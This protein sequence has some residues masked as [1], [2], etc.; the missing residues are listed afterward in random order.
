MLNFQKRTWAILLFLLVSISSSWAQTGLLI[1]ELCDPR[2]NYVDDRF[3][4]IY[5][6][7]ATPISLNGWSLVAVGN[8]SDIFT[9]QL[10]GNIQP[11]QALV[12]GDATTVEPFDVD[13]PDEAWSVSN[14]TW[15]GKVG[16]GAKLINPDDTIVDAMIAPGTTF[17][18][19][20]M[21]RNEDVLLANPEYDP[22]E[23]TITPVDLATEASPGTHVTVG[24]PVAN[25]RIGAV[26]I[27][28]S[29]PTADDPVNVTAFVV[30]TLTTIQSV[31]LFWGES[32]DEL[33]HEIIMS[34]VS[35]STYTT[36]QPIPAQTGGTEVFFMIRAINAIPDTTSSIVHSYVIPSIIDIPELQGM[37]Y[38]SPYAG[39]TVLTS[40]VIM[41]N[42]P[43]HF[44]IQDGSGAWHGVWVRTDDEYSLGDSVQVHGTVTED[45][46]QGFLATTL[47]IDTSVDVVQAGV[48]MHAPSD[49]N[50]DQAME[51]AYEGVLV[52]IDN[53]VCTDPAVGGD[54][55]WEADDGTGDILIDPLGVT[56]EPILG[57]TYQIT[58]IMVDVDDDYMLVPRDESDIVWIADD[59][60]PQMAS[61]Y[62]VDVTQLVVTFTEAVDEQSAETTQNYHVDDVAV[63]TC[64]LTGE[65]NNRVVL[66][67]DTLAS[68]EHELVVIAVE[69][70]YGN[71]IQS[72]TL[73]F[74]VSTSNEPEGYYLAAEGLVGEDLQ[75]AL[76]DIIDDHDAHSYTY[77]WTAFY[78]TD[79]KPNG[80]VWDIYSDIPGGDPPYEYT[81]GEDQGGI[82]GA[83][84]NGYT[85]EHSWPRSWFGG[86]V[87]PMNS[88][89]Y[90]IYP[91]DAHVNGN[92]GNYPYGEVDNATWTSMN[93]SKV[94]PCTV[95]GYTGTVFE[96]IDAYKGDLARTYFYMVTRYYGE[97]AAW[98]GSPMTD[99]ANLLPWAEEML[100]EWHENDP[101]SQKEVA[102]NNAAYLIQDN[103]NPF[104]DHPDFVMQMF[105]PL[106]VSDPAVLPDEWS[107]GTI[108]PNPFN[109]TANIT[110]QLTQPSYLEV[111]VY[112]TL[113]QQVATLADDRFVAGQLT[114]TF[115]GSAMSTGL[116]FIHV[117][118]PGHLNETR[119][120]L[121]L[122]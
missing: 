112:N 115:D 90:A 57:T 109:P 93:G 92:R 69:D 7:G 66:T 118:V 45:D 61:I 38:A 82:G 26:N 3:I 122:K 77:V 102:R 106:S 91:C 44:V 54:G 35:D 21:V 98:P 46:N 71:A 5:N 94:G 48:G 51:E 59:F 97:D 11:G 47:L 60:P 79:V 121:L 103:R 56:F 39:Q 83:E 100:L 8:S 75:D 120:I 86:E 68:G 40:G 37:S 53:A 9:W 34:N 62:V 20:D 43:D 4:E 52:R 105:R 70:L 78:T 117:N 29:Q 25:P 63:L 111:T 116:Y 22:S 58:G 114:L 31:E 65:M 30:D 72:D 10:S 81:L 96:P 27:D 32:E 18:N 13:F 108:Y 110:V 89:I 41:A 84:G 15:N 42:Y 14:G 1:S 19:D 119:K 64:E 33:V 67:V 113:G 16:D 87:A 88:D 36:D 104:I 74:S 17:E 55:F 28:P 101:V 50:V 49:Q 2:L 6:A 85:R 76:H 80:M 99:G 24:Q 73:Q 107:V 12:A 23:W 95:D